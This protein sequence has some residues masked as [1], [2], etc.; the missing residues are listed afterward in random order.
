MLIDLSGIKNSKKKPSR[1]RSRSRSLSKENNSYE[2][3]D[4]IEK[5]IP[6]YIDENSK[7]K[8]YY[9]RDWERKKGIR[10]WG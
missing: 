1:S 6:L 9:E 8:A 2:I 3:L 7:M 10:H 5:Q 4:K